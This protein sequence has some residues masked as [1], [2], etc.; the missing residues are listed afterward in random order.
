M[1][2]YTN[3]YLSAGKA[4]AEKSAKT[5][6]VAA[7]DS[8]KG[9]TSKSHKT[10][11]TTKT[12]A[13]STPDFTEAQSTPSSSER[14]SFK[15]PKRSNPFASLDEQSDKGKNIMKV[16]YFLSTTVINIY[17]SIYILR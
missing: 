12:P 13:R 17:T 8:D 9:P 10:G 1:Y 5:A 2:T 11:P 4:T 3:L 14:E 6:K 7:A 15:I 16:Y